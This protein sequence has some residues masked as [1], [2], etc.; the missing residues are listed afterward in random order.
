MQE[1]QQRE[2]QQGSRFTPRSRRTCDE[3]CGESKNGERQTPNRVE[4]WEPR[5]CALPT[6]CWGTGGEQTRPW[7][8]YERTSR[9]VMISLPVL[10]VAASQERDRLA[11]RWCECASLDRSTEGRGST[12]GHEQQR[13]GTEQAVRGAEVAA[14]VL[15]LLS[16]RLA[17][18]C[19]GFSLASWAGPRLRRVVPSDKRA[20][21]D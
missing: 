11:L 17:R 13:A 14:V 7:Y 20:T 9:R 5:S 3:P 6:L 12:P 8:P 21:G 4:C 10:S 16:R 2:R 19:Q 15:L 1:D 18:S